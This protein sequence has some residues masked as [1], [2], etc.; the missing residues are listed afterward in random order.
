M[1]LKTPRASERMKLFVELALDDLPLWDM[2]C[3]HGYIG[4]LALSSK[5]FS[6][7]YFVDNVDHIIKRLQNLIDQSPVKY[8]S[9]TI[10]LVNSKAEDLKVYIDG[11]CVIA[12]VGGRTIVTI[13]DTLFRNGFLR[14]LRL[15]LS[16]HTDES[17]LLEF[18]NSNNFSYFYSLTETIDF[19]EG[20]RQRRIYI[21]NIKSLP[22]NFA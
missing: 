3:D 6:H 2:C 9:S 17:Y 20:K 18:L 13:L 15:I 19:Y 12:G 16:P 4:L 10:T 1:N 5:R 14:S 22:H 21:L 8:D 11:T 7:V